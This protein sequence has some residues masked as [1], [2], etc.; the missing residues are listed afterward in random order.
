MILVVDT[1]RK[2]LATYNLLR[3]HYKRE[4]KKVFF[5]SR[6]SLSTRSY[7]WMK[8][9][10]EKR[11]KNNMQTKRSEAPF[12]QTTW[13]WDSVIF[14]WLFQRRF[15]VPIEKKSYTRSRAFTNTCKSFTF[16]ENPTLSWYSE[17]FM[18]SVIITTYAFVTKQK[19]FCKQNVQKNSIPHA[20]STWSLFI[21]LWK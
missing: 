18:R 16:L 15:L 1:R 14:V 4:R 6:F 8:K 13:T 11:Q 12:T 7:E 5:S 19:N 20:G 21:R 9:Q 10:K 3:L 17:F 2:K